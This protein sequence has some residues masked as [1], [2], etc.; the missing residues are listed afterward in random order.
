[1]RHLRI[2]CGL[3]L[4]TFFA[5]TRHADSQVNSQINPPI[6]SPTDSQTNADTAQ[7]LPSYS[8]SVSVD[9]VSLTFHAADV[10]GLPIND[11]KLNELNLRDNGKPPRKILSFQY[12]HDFPLRAG[13]VIDISQSMEDTRSVDRSIAIKYAQQLLHSQADQ[14]FVTNF[15]YLSKIAQTWTRSPDA[16]TAAIRNRHV[17]TATESHLKGT[18]LFGAIYRTCMNQFGHID[19]AASGNFILLFSDGED[20]A[21]YVSLQQA[22][23]MCQRTNTVIYAFRPPPKPTFSSTGQTT[24]AELTAQSGGRVFDEDG[25][26]ANIDD[27]LRAIEADLRNQYRLIYRPP[28]LRPDGSFHRVELNAPERVD[29]ITI[30]SGYY[31]P[32]H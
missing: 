11:L 1:M 21:G 8:L 19:N 16:L 32:A 13:I 20:N 9:E 18:A 31:A 5:H 12:L 24:L 14:A 7:N 23:D 3:I 4:L 26:E 17:I 25:P 29:R 28:E 15:D 30:R 6:N 10:H 2:V 27:D 22:V